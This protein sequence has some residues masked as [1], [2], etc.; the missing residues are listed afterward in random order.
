[1]MYQ[2]GK[3]IQSFGYVKTS[4]YD[5]NDEIIGKTENSKMKKCRKKYYYRLINVIYNIEI[6]QYF[7]L[8]TIE[9]GKIHNVFQIDWK[10]P[11][12]SAEFKPLLDLD[13]GK[14][15]FTTSIHKFAWYWKQVLWMIFMDQN[16]TLKK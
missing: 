5:K 16:I 6:N 13:Q 1:M 4:G 14:H 8:I 11:M 15:F 10:L 7:D 3:R 9:N 12:N 2:Y